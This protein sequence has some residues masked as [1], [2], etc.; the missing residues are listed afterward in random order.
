MQITRR[1]ILT[2]AASI[3]ALGVWGSRNVRSY[4]Q[5]AHGKKRIL[6]F[7][8]SAG[9]Q[10]PVITRHGNE[11]S[12]AEELMRHLGAAH[13]Y[14]ITCSKDGRLFDP[15]RI[16]RWDAF[17]FYTSGDLTTRG[18]DG[19]PPMSVA[20][21]RAFL[22]AIAGGK[23]FAGIHCAT[24]TFHSKPGHES[25]YIQMLGG[26]FIGHG[27]QQIATEL[28]IDRHFPGAGAYGEKTFQLFEEWYALD[29]LNKDM[30]A[31][32]ALRTQGLIGPQY[33]RP[34]FP[35]T[36]IRRHH[37]GRV[38][39]TAMGHKHSTWRSQNFQ[40]LLLGGLAFVTGRMDFTVRTNVALVAT[41]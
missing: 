4:S 9:F 8:K 34:N 25:A 7:T 19:Y 6:F 30:H 3:T 15:Q 22:D 5:I 18:T 21:K 24:D 36:W 40:Q 2:A 11:L 33:R 23:G 1:N 32:F 17:I 37:A 27:N 12:F 10:H 38:F 16:G 39:Y 20:G 31:I 28:I 35:N 13:G 41:G 14:E 26:E 29:N